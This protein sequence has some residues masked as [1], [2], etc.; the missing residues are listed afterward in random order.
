VLHRFTNP[1]LNHTCSKVAADGSQKLPERFEAVI[2]AREHAGLPTARFSAVTALWLAA[3][4]GLRLASGSLPAIEDP[5]ANHL[6]SIAEEGDLPGL[7]RSAV[8]AWTSE[9]LQ[10]EVVHV[11]DTLRRDGVEVL[12]GLR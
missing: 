3:A 9:T 7:V 11:L 8:G 1:A 5:M 10:Q 4:S 2:A 6:V 12:G